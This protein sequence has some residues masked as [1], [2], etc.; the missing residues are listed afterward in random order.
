VDGGRPNTPA[1][2]SAIGFVL[3]GPLWLR[4]DIHD[5]LT[6]ELLGH[7]RTGDFLPPKDLAARLE[8]DERHLPELLMSLGYTRRPRGRF[9]LGSPR[10]RRDG[11]AAHRDHRTPAALTTS[12]SEDGRHK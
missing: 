9:S 2:A 6:M 10:R 8:C 4:V 5:R 1:F 12:E 11:M 7:S 3:Q